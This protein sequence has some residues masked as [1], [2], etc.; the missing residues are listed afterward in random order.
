[1]LHAA[2]GG[3]RW[4]FGFVENPLDAMLGMAGFL[5]FYYFFLVSKVFLKHAD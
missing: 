5:G 1:M 4:L 3:R 2:R